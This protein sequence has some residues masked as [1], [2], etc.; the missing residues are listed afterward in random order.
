MTATIRPPGTKKPSDPDEFRMTIG[1]HLE[2]LRHRIILGLSGFIVALVICTPFAKRLLSFICQ[3]L[4]NAEVANNINPQ[5]FASEA[6]EPFMC[7][8]RVSLI[9]A[10]SLAGPWLVLQIWQ[11]IAA[12]LY[13]NERKAVTRYIPLATV[14]MLSGMAFVY[15]IVLPLTM[16]FFVGFAMTIP[17]QLPLR[18]SPT[19]LPSAPESFVQALPV[20]PPNPRPYQMWYNTSEGRLKLDVGDAIGVLA[21]GSDS[22]MAMHIE[23]SEYLDLVFRLLITFGLCFQLPLVVMA[24]V[25]LGIIDI[26]TLRYYRRHVYFGMAVLAAAVSPG[27]VVTATLALLAPLILLY[28]FGILLAKMN[29]PKPADA[30]GV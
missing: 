25:R 19:T 20:D 23:L 16:R 15:W 6:T 21:Y 28:E 4:I 14:L 2:E 11:F 9:A 12:G 8:V 30:G 7:W 26:A 18:E 10:V 27:D 5:F 17:I 3:P 1:E 13:P 29:M 22:L 24:L